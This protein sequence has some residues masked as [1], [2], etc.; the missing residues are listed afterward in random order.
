MISYPTKTKTIRIPMP[1]LSRAE[2]YLKELRGAGLPYSFT[3][4]LAAGLDLAIR[5]QVFGSVNF[6]GKDEDGP[7]G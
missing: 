5:E 2:E 1:L 4:L 3:D 7:A 6:N